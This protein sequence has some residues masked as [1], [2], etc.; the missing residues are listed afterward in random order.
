MRLK[1]NHFW[2]AIFVS[3]FLALIT[4]FTTFLYDDWS[5][6]Y[7]YNIFYLT[8]F[9]FMVLSLN[10]IFFTKHRRF[11]NPKLRK[12]LRIS[13]IIIYSLAYLIATL[14]F[15]TTGEITRIQ[16][17]LFLSQMHPML[18]TGII[19]GFVAL[20]ILLI[21]FAF[22][23]KTEIPE[24]E[25]EERGKIKIIFYISIVL[26][27]ITILVNS[28]FLR[29]ENPLISNEEALISYLG[30]EPILGAKVSS[31]NT[32]LYDKPNV[33]FILLEALSAER[34][35]F[36]GYERN[37]TP[38]MDKLANKSTIFTNAY[39]TS[40]HSDYA[41]PGLLSSRYMF[42]SKYRKIF[43]DDNPRKFIWDIFKEDNYTT[44]YYSSQDDRWQNMDHYLDY[45]N[46]DD[47]SNSMTDGKTDYGNGLARKDYD[48]KTADLAVEWLN[49]T[50]KKQEPFFLY[51]NFQATHLPR[52]YPPN[53]EYFKPENPINKYDNSLRYV[54]L[55]VGKI[56]DFIEENNLSNN[57]IIAI[58]SDHG[59]D[60]EKRHGISN[61]GKS[62][63]E[64]ELIVPALIFLPRRE[65]KVKEERVSHIDFVP[66][67]IDLLGYPIPKEFQGD[68]MRK[69]RPI[70]LVA[71]SHKY[72]I[73]LIQNDTKII[74]D[75]NKKLS[76]VYD[77]KNDPKELNN[78]D[79][80]EYNDLMLKLLFWHYCQK[81]Y[82]EK[83]RWKKDSINRCS[84]NNNFKI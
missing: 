74:L 59:E 66:T 56:I 84:L 72:L 38:N 39:T 71:Q 3:L 47:V 53:Y 23:R 16:T 48:H 82:Y 42:T 61:H 45:T 80:K 30:E 77:L 25:E 36:Y 13:F 7:I 83:Q 79:S 29:I 17:I 65:P 68:L 28:V 63:Y 34:I 12:F 40:T 14:S 10:A 2:V 41:Q 60:L 22:Y 18:I 69:N 54:D 24:A 33:I 46:L 19:V 75:M 73:G 4:I 27:I 6:R 51:L 57:T 15:I 9:N 1:F 76:E 26:F 50:I 70:F 62:I 49:K 31:I 5:I 43:P 78:I 35:G 32:T 44:G 58:T 52:S 55:Q 21:V 64:E 81:D 67:L 37:V 11:L 20:S 8:L